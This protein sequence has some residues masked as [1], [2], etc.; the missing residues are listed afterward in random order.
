MPRHNQSNPPLHSRTETSVFPQNCPYFIFMMFYLFFEESKE[1]I[2]EY[3]ESKPFY[4]CFPPSIVS[5]LSHQALKYGSFLAQG[6]TNKTRAI[7]CP[8]SCCLSN[9]FINTSKSFFF[10]WKCLCSRKKEACH[11]SETVSEGQ[12]VDDIGHGELDFRLDI[13]FGDLDKFGRQFL[14]FMKNLQ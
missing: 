8:E 7:P 5:Y 11:P 1:F 12:L 14:N 4:S 6:N 13:D 9:K 2:P 3:H 10:F